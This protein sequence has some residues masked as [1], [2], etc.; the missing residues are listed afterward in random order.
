MH[1][2]YRLYCPLVSASQPAARDSLKVVPQ[3]FDAYSCV[4]FESVRLFHASAAALKPIGS[5]LVLAFDT[6]T[7]TNDVNAGVSQMTRKWNARLA[8]AGLGLAVDRAP[9]DCPDV[10]RVAEIP[11]R[12]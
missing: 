6:D 4:L 1:Y 3:L 8:G 11:Q 5:G 2:E 7:P 12:G 10:D 9:Q